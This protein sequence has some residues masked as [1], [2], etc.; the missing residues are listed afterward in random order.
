MTNYPRLVQLLRL[1]DVTRLQEGDDKAHLLNWLSMLPVTSAPV[2][3][4]CVYPQFVEL[5]AR[6]IAD[7]TPEVA[8]ATVVN[9]PDGKQPLTTVLADIQRVLA[10]GANEIDCVL[11]YHTLLDGDET[12]VLSFLTAVREASKDVCLKII[13]ESGELLTAQQIAKATELVIASGA[14]FVKTSTGKV[15]VGVTLEAA[16]II[17]TSIAASG[18][19]VGFK[20]SGGVKTVQQALELV[21]LYENIIGKPAISTGIRIGASTLLTELCQQ[22][23]A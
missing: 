18:R 5:T 10:S 19:A 23:S 14:D 15:P 17:L 9:F 8:L 7:N 20:A 2:A 12:A 1:L 13:I 6:F 3:A 11:P 22:L 4:Y 21:D 16:R